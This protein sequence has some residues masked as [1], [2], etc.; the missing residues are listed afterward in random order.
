MSLMLPWTNH[1]SWLLLR[2]VAVELHLDSENVELEN[3]AGLE[4]LQLPIENQV[5]WIPALHAYTRF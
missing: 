2:T 3:Q 4:L 1:A 5:R